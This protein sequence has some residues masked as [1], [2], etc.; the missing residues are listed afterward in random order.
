MGGRS[1]EHDVSL[2]TARAVAGTLGELGWEWLEVC[3]EREGGARWESRGEGG[4]TPPGA[5]SR[6]RGTTL[7]ALGA[8]VAYAPHAAFIAM[9]GPDGEDGRLQAVLELCGVP[10]QGSDAAASAIA[11][12]KAR[13][14]ALY[15]TAGLPVA[16]DRVVRRGEAP[17][18]DE[19]AS[20]LGL[21]LVLKT[22][23]S[24][25]SVGV[26]VVDSAAA[27]SV[28]GRAMLEDT[29][30]LV[31]ERWLPGAEFTVAVLEDASGAPE[32]LPV[33]EIR[34][35]TARFFDYVTKYDPE[36]TDEICPAPIAEALAQEL[37]DLGL[38]AHRVLGCRDYSRT[39]I[40]L[41][42]ERR[43]HLLETN[44]LP[45]LTPASLF[46]KAARTAGIPFAEV[47]RRLVTRAAERAPV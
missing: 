28:R 16:E 2:V 4:G 41:D 12:D 34:P 44:T 26:E 24:G 20:R 15:R 29:T 3:F 45:G 33:I 18:W 39:D 11:M 43:P 42:A 30:H 25:S 36:A 14:K 1:G 23:K 37:R 47:V 38:A 5:T 8:V 22:A 17:A 9:H 40:K 21:P 10:Y 27:L 31:I 46:P 19:I 35:K 32:A 13:T 7:D 6:T